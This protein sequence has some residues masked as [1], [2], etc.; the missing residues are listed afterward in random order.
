M[1]HYASRF[2]IICELDCRNETWQKCNAQG[3]IEY[4]GE[5]YVETKE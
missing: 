4:E 1:Q 5:T 3:A 2:I